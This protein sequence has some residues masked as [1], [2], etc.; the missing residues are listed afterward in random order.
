MEIGIIAVVINAGKM[1]PVSVHGNGGAAGRGLGGAGDGH[2]Q[3]VTAANLGGGLR[4]DSLDQ[5]H[6]AHTN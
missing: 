3:G 5:A 6:Q 2:R 1:P 4:F